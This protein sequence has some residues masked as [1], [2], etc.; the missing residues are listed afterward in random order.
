MRIPKPEYNLGLEW[1]SKEISSEA[2]AHLEVVWNPLKAISCREVIDIVDH[3]GNRKS[4]SIILKSCELKKAVVRKTGS[5]NDYNKKLKLKAPSPP[6]II[7]N[8][9][10]ISVQSRRRRTEFMDNNIVE[11]YGSENI[12]VPMQQISP[13]KRA[14]IATNFVISPLRNATNNQS[15]DDHELFHNNFGKENEVVLTPTTYNASTMF[16]SIRFTPLTET[17]PKGESKLEYLSS[18]PT[19]VTTKRDDISVPKEI[20]LR[21]NLM[22]AGI[23]PEMQTP[24]VISRHEMGA[25]DQRYHTI[26]DKTPRRN[27]F[28]SSTCTSR[29]TTNQLQTRFELA[30]N[31]NEESDEHL[32]YIKGPSSEEI[33]EIEF[34]L[35]TDQSG[36]MSKTQTFYTPPTIEVSPPIRQMDDGSKLQTTFKVDKSRSFYDN[37]RTDGFE[38]KNSP[39][40]LS[41]SM[42]EPKQPS[43]TS[44]Q[45]ATL[46]SNQ[47]SM[48][49]LNDINMHHIEHNRYFYQQQ[50]VEMIQQNMSMESVVS[51]VD[52][53]EIETCAQSSRLNLNE[54]GR[55]K[56]ASSPIIRQ[57]I[58]E[59]P[60]KY[61]NNG[62]KVKASP[63]KYCLSPTIQRIREE[64]EDCSYNDKGKKLLIF[65]PPKNKLSDIS[66]IYRR[67][68]FTVATK[69]EIRAT[70]WKQQQNQHTFAIPKVPRESIFRPS[71]ST[72][73]QSLTSLSSSMTSISSTCSMPATSG[74]LYNENL[75]NAYTQ[76]DPFSA[77][78][79][80]DPFLS[81]SM[82]LDERTL[83]GIEKSFKKWLNALV[84]IPPDL[85]ADRNEKIDVAKLFNDVQTKELTLAP[86]KELVCSQY[87]TARLDQL[88][89]AAVRLFHSEQI[90]KP[91]NK[92]A[93]I[94]N[95]K[96][97]LEVHSARHINL[98]IV[99]ASIINFN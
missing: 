87:Y 88:R 53:K 30:E 98:D 25:E 76:R 42:C 31:D 2:C 79:T 3:F 73:S 35:T 85:E 99:S 39:R 66:E 17:K 51:N 10:H 36:V 65:S 8:R 78:T 68:T 52:F 86:T 38:Y 37:L 19:P 62:K 81:S 1:M 20:L 5:G 75:I 7:L 91:L 84:T 96:K 46:K 32:T 14:Q 70:T 60:L 74:K 16:N 64:Q 45:K 97:L 83:D 12:I 61:Q 77:T 9:H 55:P 24:Q 94:I 47:G 92:L 49:N 23:S 15:K 34:I 22:Q 28:M 69:G 93:V 33:N 56:K 48:P 95:E 58:I 27:V 4:V 6:K 29:V 80:E 54:I 59:S 72:I 67:E 50:Q 41:E 11:E 63:S 90:S 13:V 43:P 40:L 44:S 57:E 18:L 26:I 21:K 71:S 82:Y 89:G